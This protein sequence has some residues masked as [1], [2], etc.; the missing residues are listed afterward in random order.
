MLMPMERRRSVVTCGTNPDIH[1]TRYGVVRVYEADGENWVTSRKIWNQHAYFNVN[2]NDDGTVPIEQQKHHLV[3]S[4]GVCGPN[5]RP[6]NTFLNQSPT[7][8]NDGC[9]DYAAADLD[10]GGNVVLT[11]PT[12]PNK[13]FTI[14]FDISNIGDRTL[15]GNVPIT[16]YDSDPTVAGATKLNTVQPYIDLDRGETITL[17]NL[18]VHGTGGDFTLHI[19]I[20]DDGSMPPPIAYPISSFLECNYDNNVGTAAIQTCHFPS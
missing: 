11:P 5:V 2:I 15:R 9:S 8:T 14:S 3:F 12:C 19:A 20:N 4:S 7:L 6:L 16:F 17:N 13:Y 18:L 10:F 1:Q